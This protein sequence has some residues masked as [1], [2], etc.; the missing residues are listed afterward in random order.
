MKNP[1]RNLLTP[2]EQKILLFLL[3]FAFLGLIL[4]FTGAP[5][6]AEETIADSLDFSKDYEIKYDLK[7]CTAKE[8][9][10]IPG[11]GP[12]TASKI[13]TYRE[14]AGFSNLEEII[15]V[16][17]IGVATLEKIRPYFTEFTIS[18]S[19][20]PTNTKQNKTATTNKININTAGAEELSELPAIG[21]AKAARI[22]A[23]RKELG[24]FQ[25]LEQITEVKG[26]GIKTFVKLQN[27]ITLGAE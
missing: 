22:I 15:N 5:V 23:K 6:H 1:L 14:Q 8:L 16:K 25:T 27:K 18:D 26:I 2:D 7:T 24:G 12:S 3:C 20:N 17:G 10:T 11:I 9:E 13:I 19:T 21:P 4:K